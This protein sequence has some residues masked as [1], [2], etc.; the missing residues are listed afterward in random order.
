[1]NLDSITK[2]MLTQQAESNIELICYRDPGSRISESDGGFHITNDGTF[3]SLSA[4]ALN[5][6]PIEI[7]ALDYDCDDEDLFDG[8]SITNDDFDPQ[9]ALSGTSYWKLLEIVIQPDGLI[10]LAFMDTRPESYVIEADGRIS[11]S[12]WETIIINSE[13]THLT[14]VLETENGHRQFLIHQE[15]ISTAEIANTNIIEI[16]DGLKI[17]R[18]STEGWQNGADIPQ[19]YKNTYEPSGN[20][21]RDT[22][23]HHYSDQPGA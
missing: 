13:L 16:S 3:E 1:M 21:P 14:V 4:V 19:W 8:S 12:N 5:T 15:F 6:T 23:P 22:S 10:T 20:T 7:F 11:T 9:A 17:S 2:A 18:L